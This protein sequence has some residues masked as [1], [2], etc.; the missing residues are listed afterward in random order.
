MFFKFSFRQYLTNPQKLANELQSSSIRGF[1]IRVVLVFL[2]GV[3]LFGLRSL[4]GMNTEAITP[5]IISTSTADF[6]LARF[7]SLLGSMVWSVIYISFH[8]FGFAFILSY[9]IGIPFKKLLPMQLLMTGLLLIEKALVF[10]VFV[11]KGEIANVS[12]L[13]FGPLA[14][15]FIEPPF[16]IFLFNQ[17]TLTTII[18]VAYQYHFIRKFSEIVQRKRLIWLLI[19]LHL[20][21]AIITASIGFIPAESLFDTITGGGV[22]NE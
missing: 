11:M 19:G 9:L 1:K 10:L 17:L 12:F 6:T 4:W 21:M 14:T 3:L 16:F 5:L 15:T 18:I 2:A 20:L 22:G 13:S 7:A 8:L